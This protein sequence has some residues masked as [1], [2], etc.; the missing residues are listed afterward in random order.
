MV[1]AICIIK[2][3]SIE[4]KQR[5]TPRLIKSFENINGIECRASIK[6]VNSTTDLRSKIYPHL[7]KYFDIADAATQDSDLICL[8]IECTIRTDGMGEKCWEPLSDASEREIKYS[9]LSE[10]LGTCTEIIN[11][12]MEDALVNLESFEY[13]W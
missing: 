8:Y 3:V 6:L 5:F 4:Q 1:T 12:F 2:D 9:V 7:I 10:I 13:L 11:D